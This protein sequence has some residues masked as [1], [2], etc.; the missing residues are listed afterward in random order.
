MR[1][2][3]LM[4]LL[5]TCFLGS[6]MGCA[7]VEGNAFNPYVQSRLPAE[8]M[9]SESKALLAPI[10]GREATLQEEASHRKNWKEEAYPVVFG[11]RKAA[12]EIMVLLD[13]ASP[14][15]E[16]LWREVVRASKMLDPGKSKIVVF[17]NSREQYGTELMGG[18]IW[19]VCM[20]PEKSMEYYTFTLNRWNSAKARQKQQGISRTFS[21][22]YDATAGPT[23]KPILYAF[24][25]Q[26]R[27]PVP[28][29]TQVDI[30]RYS[31]DA[32]NVNLFQA[33]TVAR[34]YGVERLPAVV[35]N[36]TVVQKPTAEKIV[37]AA[38]R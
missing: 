37:A 21:Y 2:V 4:T 14:E 6:A 35:V 28:G 10:G 30:V 29:E 19:T 23:E 20:R 18:G 11:N 33:V 26:L 36:D 9:N 5:C 13:Y 3:F 15:S 12:N 24:L 22:E 27:P 31:F 32:G 7:S 8:E 38:T 1:A 17:G 16:A 34:H 25:E